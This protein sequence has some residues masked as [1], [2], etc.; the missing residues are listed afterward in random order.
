MFRK[1]ASF[2]ALNPH[3]LNLPSNWIPG[4]PDHCT[5][6]QGRPS[7][8]GWYR[9]GKPTKPPTHSPYRHPLCRPVLT[10]PFFAVAD[11]SGRHPTALSSS[12][13]QLNGNGRSGD[14]LGRPC[15][16]CG[17]H[18]PKYQPVLWGGSFRG[19]FTGAIEKG[20]LTG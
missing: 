3:L 12:V 1:E 13:T 6:G 10:N 19:K 14:M 4:S 7:A 16:L 11:P 5:C 20:C 15:Y 17:I 2:G 9:P 8:N 18:V